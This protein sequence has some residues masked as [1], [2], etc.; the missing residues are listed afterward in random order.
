ME[1]RRTKAWGEKVRS[2]LEG[3]KLRR[4]ESTMA[5]F[6]MFAPKLAKPTSV[7]EKGKVF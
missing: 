7:S 3:F 6:L 1:L 4:D 2:K 5:R